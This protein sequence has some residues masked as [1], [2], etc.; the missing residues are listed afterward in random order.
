[1]AELAFSTQIQGASV[2]I[3]IHYSLPFCTVVDVVVCSYWKFQ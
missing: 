3:R 2:H 1:M